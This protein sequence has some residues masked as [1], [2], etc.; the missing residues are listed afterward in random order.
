MNRKVEY[1]EWAE[2]WRGPGKTIRKTKQGYG[3]YR[4][5]SVYVPGSK[6]KSVQEYLGKITPEGFIPKQKKET[7]NSVRLEYGLSRFLA[8]NFKRELMRKMYGSD[9]DVAELVIIR[10]IF[11]STDKQ[12][13]SSSFLTRD[14]ADRLSERMSKLGGTRVERFSVALENMVRRKI[15][16]SSIRRQIIV[17]LLMLTVPESGTPIPKIPDN[18]ALLIEREG[19]RYE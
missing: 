10:C 18:L 16:D 9:S 2:K 12:Y 1:P 13:L 7:E 8:L 17:G 5:T 11:G 14:H 4:C 6:P 15:P 3:L 19:L